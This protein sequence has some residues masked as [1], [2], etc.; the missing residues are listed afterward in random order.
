[1]ERLGFDTQIDF[2]VR[3]SVKLKVVVASAESSPVQWASFRLLLWL[4]SSKWLLLCP[5]P[6]MAIG[7]QSLFTFRNVKGAAEGMHMRNLVGLA[8]LL[9]RKS[10]LEEEDRN[11]PPPPISG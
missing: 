1:M 6:C 5:S 3:A 7:L 8:L 11:P 2:F 4:R 10:R 9:K